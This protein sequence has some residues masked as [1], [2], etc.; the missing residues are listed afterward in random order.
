MRI[1]TNLAENAVDQITCDQAIR[2]DG[3]SYSRVSIFWSCQTQNL[4]LFCSIILPIH[5]PISLQLNVQL[6][7]GLDQRVVF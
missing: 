7:Y 5:L 3:E 4:Q 6:Y 2:Q 1:T